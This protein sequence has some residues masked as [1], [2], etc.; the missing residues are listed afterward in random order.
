[1]PVVRY[2]NV[3]CVAQ[4]KFVGQKSR[5][6]TAIDAAR[7]ENRKNPA[8]LDKVANDLLLPHLD[9]TFAVQLAL[10]SRIRRRCATWMAK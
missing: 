9:S 1:V 8:A 5:L 3:Q 4:G 7:E 6:L 2:A 10:V